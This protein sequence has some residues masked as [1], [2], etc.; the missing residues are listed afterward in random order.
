MSSLLLVLL[1]AVS[2]E[3]T[4]GT[5][6]ELVDE[7][8]AAEAVGIARE[9]LAEYPDDAWLQKALALALRNSEELEAALGIYEELLEHDRDDDDAR[10]GK[11]IT[12]SWMDRLEEAVAVYGEVGPESD[13]YYEALLGIGQVR[14]WQGRHHEAL[15]AYA[16]AESLAPQSIEV[17][18]RQAQVLKWMGRYGLS[19]ARYRDILGK[20]P[21]EAEAWFG[22][23]QAYE[24]A[25]FPSRARERYQR[26]VE[27]EPEW[28]EPAV[29]L[30]RL[31]LDLGT[32][33]AVEL[34]GRW[35]D[36][37]GTK[38]SYLDT[39]LEVDRWF[40]DYLHPCVSVRYSDNARG[41][42][43]EDYL[44]GGAELEFR[45]WRPL[46]LSARAEADV[47]TASLL[48]CS[49]AGHLEL[50]M[51]NWHGSAGRVL[52]EPGQRLGAVNCNTTLRLEP[53]DGLSIAG[54]FTWLAVQDTLNNSKLAASGD[55]SYELFS[56]PAISLVY[57]YAFDSFQQESPQY[58]TPQDLHT[59]T[60]GLTGFKAFGRFYASADFAAGLNTDGIQA[61]R[62]S[63]ELEYD[64]SDAL[65]LFVAG[66]FFQTST[67]Y[68]NAEMSVGVTR[69]LPAR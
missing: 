18:L 33:V 41:T 67:Q 22:M 55:I 1:L 39:E 49:G 45:P 17:W 5:V 14:S 34:N 11:A 37:A 48:E 16:R 23:G 10:L 32:R 4:I 38:G 31:N 6:H 7:G 52:F 24:W 8:R 59:H 36:D 69:V 25:G 26:A 43:E 3:A 56:D 40:G 51:F 20:E 12:L 53:V 13:E 58:Y 50:G 42:L 64:L 19:V 21:D 54:S 35:D 65:A 44:L 46:T 66:G 15:E 27:L 2:P 68:V 60:L 9:A 28:D 61:M 57:G 47:L 29:A 63:V 30:D 62:G